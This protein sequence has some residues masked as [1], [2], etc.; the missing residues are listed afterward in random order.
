MHK[1]NDWTQI[2]SSNSQISVMLVKQ[3]LEE[4]GIEAVS[5][6]QQDSSY[7]FGDIQLYVVADQYEKA[8]IIM[9]EHDFEN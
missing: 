9:D 4:N 2:Y 6:N 7:L 3:I 8:K 1:T 5:L